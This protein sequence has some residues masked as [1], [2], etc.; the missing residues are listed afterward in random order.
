MY[1]TVPEASI[2]PETLGLEDLFPFEKAFFQ[3]LC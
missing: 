1:G 2:A 3:G